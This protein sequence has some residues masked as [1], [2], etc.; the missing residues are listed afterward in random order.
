MLSMF[1]TLFACAPIEREG[2]IVGNP[3]QTRPSFADIQPKEDNGSESTDSETP[4]FWYTGT[5][6]VLV[7]VAL[8][9]I[10][11][12]RLT[13][14]YNQ[15]MTLLGED[16]FDLPAGQWTSMI[17]TFEDIYISGYFFEDNP[18]LIVV[19]SFELELYSPS[20]NTDS[21]EII[22]E[23]GDAGWLNVHE[24]WQSNDDIVISESS[25]PIAFQSLSRQSAL[26]QDLDG[27][28]VISIDER[29]MALLAAGPDRDLGDI[30]FM[31]VNSE[32]TKI[33]SE[34]GCHAAHLSQPKSTIVLL[35]VGLL[36][37]LATRRRIPL[38]RG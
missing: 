9:D 13:E 12:Q 2:T 1:F 32:S 17:A 4:E 27:N 37:V 38:S 14:V 8:V 31:N 28:Q 29:E 19:D 34:T 36:G 25:N 10:N 26:F 30:E 5:E 22:L 24:D 6:G 33:S 7:E 3:S 20:F 35:L 21:L 11:G 16:V 18:H 15:H 23:I